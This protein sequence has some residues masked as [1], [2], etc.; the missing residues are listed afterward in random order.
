[1]KDKKCCRVRVGLRDQ[2]LQR[3]QGKKMVKRCLTEKRK[4]E[5]GEKKSIRETEKRRQRL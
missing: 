2:D 3:I 1:M 5:V 4:L